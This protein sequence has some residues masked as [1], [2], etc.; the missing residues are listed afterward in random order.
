MT[1]ISS[2]VTVV[3][4]SPPRSLVPTP[5]PQ[6]L[7]MISSF[8]ELTYPRREF[9]IHMGKENNTYPSEILMRKG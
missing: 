7:S 3:I 9:T 6:H 1:F 8:Y 2:S 5:S 4:L